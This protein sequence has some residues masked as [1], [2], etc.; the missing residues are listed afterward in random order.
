MSPFASFALMASIAASVT[1]ALVVCVLV[2]R[3]GFTIPAPSDADAG[4]SPTD[5]LVTRVG[6]AVAAACFAATGVLAVVALSLRAPD[7]VPAVPATAGAS[8]SALPS[9][10]VS[11]PVESAEP[12]LTA[13]R[14][15]LADAEAQ[16][17]R[18]DT[19]VRCAPPRV[20][21]VARPAVRTRSDAPARRPAVTTGSVPTAHGAQRLL[22]TTRKAWEAS[23]HRAADFVGG[24]HTAWV[25]VE[26]AVARHVGGDGVDREATRD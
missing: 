8:P 18:L 23:R 14:Q 20:A 19:E 26:R 17:A 25:R 16:L 24:V 12:D 6:H 13:L 5:V 10:A 9:A 15:R 2:F 1:G 4:P 22:A 3:Y 11:A 7:R 21:S